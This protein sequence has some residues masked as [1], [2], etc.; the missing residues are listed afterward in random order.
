[1]PCEREIPARPGSL[2]F[3][4]L[5]GSSIRRLLL[6][7]PA[8]DLRQALGHLK[9]KVVAVYPVGH[10]DETLTGFQ[11]ATHQAVKAFVP[12]LVSEAGLAVL[13]DDEESQS[14]GES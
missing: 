3:N 1:M 4:Y 7:L 8:D 2:R 11:N 12:S 9:A 13:N 10:P 6:P 14:L 5:S